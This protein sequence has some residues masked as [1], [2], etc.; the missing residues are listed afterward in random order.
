MEMSLFILDLVPGHTAAEKYVESSQRPP[1]H[2]P[3]IKRAAI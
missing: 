3:E 1:T 2:A